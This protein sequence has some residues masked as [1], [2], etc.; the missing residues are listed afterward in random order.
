MYVR[1]AQNLEKKKPGNTIRAIQQTK[2]NPYATQSLGVESSWNAI[3]Y[4]GPIKPRR[5]HLLTS[6]KAEARWEEN[7]EGIPRNSQ[8]PESGT[9]RVDFSPSFLLPCLL[10]CAYSCPWPSSF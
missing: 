2:E 1:K 7:P 4:P 8:S 5:L 9:L 6:E 10:P 3:V